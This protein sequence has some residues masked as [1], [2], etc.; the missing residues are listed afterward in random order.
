M[1]DSADYNPLEDAKLNI[2]VSAINAFNEEVDKRISITPKLLGKHP[3]GYDHFQYGVSSKSPESTFIAFH[4]EGKRILLVSYES[5]IEE[6]IIDPAENK[7]LKDNPVFKN[8]RPLH[9][10]DEVIKNT[11]R[12]FSDESDFNK[13]LENNDIN[14]S[15][16]LSIDQIVEGMRSSSELKERLDR[17]H[18]HEIRT[19]RRGGSLKS[20]DNPSHNERLGW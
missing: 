2:I 13:Y 10:K 6:R 1:K 5:F 9:Y 18:E 7:F 14:L 8:C 15:S 12:M 11:G 3:E 17:L 4:G 19:G 16:M 20:S